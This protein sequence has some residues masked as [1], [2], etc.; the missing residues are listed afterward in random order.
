M[1]VG[2]HLLHSALLSPKKKDE[3]CL[4]VQEE[5]P[6]LICSEAK[7]TLDLQYRLTSEHKFKEAFLTWCSQIIK[8]VLVYSEWLGLTEGQKQPVVV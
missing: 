2:K 6:Y 3:K 5:V 1:Q 7:V 4:Q 8:A